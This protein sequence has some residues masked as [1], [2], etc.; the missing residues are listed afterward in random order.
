MIPRSRITSVAYAIRAEKATEAATAA[1]AATSP[2]DEDWDVSGSNVYLP[3]G[4]VGIGT[5]TPAAKLEIDGEVKIGNTGAVCSASNEGATRYNSSSKT[6]EFCNGTSW[7]EFGGGLVKYGGSYLTK[8][9]AC[10]VVNTITSDCSC[11]SGYTAQQV[12]QGGYYHSAPWDTY[13]FGY[14]CE[15]YP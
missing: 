7:S 13:Y 2:A 4:N 15:K 10:H 3:S 14:V 5:T 1:Y 12:S 11:P 9:G 8:N 6:M